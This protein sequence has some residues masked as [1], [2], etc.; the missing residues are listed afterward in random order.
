MIRFQKI[1]RGI[2]MTDKRQTED[3][4]NQLWHRQAREKGW[5]AKGAK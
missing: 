5:M 1:W 3:G 4:A 2:N